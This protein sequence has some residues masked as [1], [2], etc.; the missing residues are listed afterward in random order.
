MLTRSRALGLVG[1][2]ALLFAAAAC[3]DDDNPSQDAGKDAVV[4]DGGGDIAPKPDGKTPTPDTGVPDQG[5]PDIPANTPTHSFCATPKALTLQNGAVEV[6]E[7][8]GLAVNEYG[9]SITCTVWT[10]TGFP[11]KQLYY[12]VPLEAGKTYLV[13]LEPQAV[14]LALYAFPAATS[15]DAASINAAC[16]DTSLDTPDPP[17]L[18]QKGQREQFLITPSKSEDWVVVVDG[19]E[20]LSFGNFKLIVREHTTPT[21]AA[22]DKAETLTLPASGPATAEGNTIGGADAFPG[23]FCGKNNTQGQP[24]LLKGSQRFYAIDLK[25]SLPYTIKFTPAFFGTLVVFP[26][27]AACQQ[28]AIETACAGAD[29]IRVDAASFQ[30]SSTTFVPKQDGSYILAVDS[31]S[32][33]LSGTYKLSVEKQSVIVPTL[34]APFSL[35]FEANCGGLKAVGDWECGQLAFKNTTCSFN[36]QTPPLGGHS[37]N[38]VWGT[39]LNDCH[40][41]SGNAGG[42]N[43]ECINTTPNDDSVLKFQVTIPAGWTSATLTYWEWNDMFTKFDFGEVRVNGVVAKA[44]CDPYVKPTAWTKQTLDLSAYAGTTI[45]IGFHFVSTAAVNY[46]GWYLDDIGVSGS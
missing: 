41:N 37:G 3:S 40:N 27:S 26:A 30:S 32:T 29:G 6:S 21:N 28:S 20:A 31:S 44:V 38:G 1:T 22:C 5:T 4:A 46:A 43:D 12:K 34:T 9:A 17:G 14:D 35:D 24:M 42:P 13:R 7:S 19:F 45:E 8:T 11:G 23:L 10:A 18:T 2:L 25:K 15:C 39:V 33:L 36:K 16:K